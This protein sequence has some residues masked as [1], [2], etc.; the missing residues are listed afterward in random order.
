MATAVSNMA[1]LCL[2]NGKI[3]FKADS[4]KICLMESGFTFDPDDDS[5][6]A[7]VSGEELADGHGYS[8]DTKVLAGV[9]ITKNDVANRAE[10]TFNNVTW[11]AVGGDI[12][13]TPGAIIYDDSVVE[14]LGDE[15]PDDPIIGYIDFGG[16]IIQASGGVMTIANIQIDI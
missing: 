2:A 3:D 10:I 6:W 1:R 8:Q 11:T 5:K 12:G 16:E 13:P 15:T 14:D 7:D 9:S 4:L